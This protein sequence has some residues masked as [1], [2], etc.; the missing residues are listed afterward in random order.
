MSNE[1]IRAA[2]VMD[3][4]AKREKASQEASLADRMND[5]V[6]FDAAPSEEKPLFNSEENVDE[7]VRGFLVAVTGARVAYLQ[8]DIKLDDLQREIK[9]KA[10]ECQDIL[11][12]RS[13]D[14]V[15]DGWNSEPQLGA[16]LVNG[17][18]VGG[19]TGDAVYRL[20]GKIFKDY[21]TVLTDYEKGVM[22]EEQMQFNVDAII[23]DAVEAF[24]GV[25][26]E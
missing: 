12:G 13:H 7:L 21:A 4:L 1:A 15:Y 6:L 18:G 26:T 11:Y 8:G 10:K 24:T 2:A 14:F 9:A 20:L 25:A 3:R 19:D 23:E 16:F 22:Q 17:Y 5:S